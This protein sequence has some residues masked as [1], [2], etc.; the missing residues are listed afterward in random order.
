[1][2]RG[3]SPTSAMPVS[4]E[5]QPPCESAMPGW[6]WRT[7]CETA[8]EPKYDLLIVDAFSSDA[9]PVHL[10]TDEACDIYGRWW[11]RMGRGVPHHEPFLNLEPVLA[12][13]AEESKWSGYRY[14]YFKL[15]NGAAFD[16]K[17]GETVSSWVFLSANQQALGSLASDPCLRRSSESPS[18]GS[19]RTTTRTCS[20]CS[21]GGSNALLF[22]NDCRVPLRL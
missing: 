3:I 21:S 20:V 4:A 22:L 6:C 1:M 19:G 17:T 12:K 7:N 13:L 16:E 11:L 8:S 15:D 9:I 10:I 5:P 14:D 2:R 18:S